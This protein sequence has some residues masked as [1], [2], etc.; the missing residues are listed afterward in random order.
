M[1][2]EGSGLVFQDGTLSGVTYD[3]SVNG[4]KELR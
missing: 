1:V 2:D 4:V 3:G